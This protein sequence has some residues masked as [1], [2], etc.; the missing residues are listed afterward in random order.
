VVVQFCNKVTSDRKGSVQPQCCGSLKE[1]NTRTVSSGFDGRVSHSESKLETVP[2]VL[3]VVEA[4]GPLEDD[5]DDGDDDDEGIVV[6]RGVVTVFP[7]VSMSLS[8]S[9]SLSLSLALGV[10]AID[11]SRHL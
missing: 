3:R 8:I 9:I 11:R 10:S 2:D 7:F 5:D 4:T 6:V 1:S